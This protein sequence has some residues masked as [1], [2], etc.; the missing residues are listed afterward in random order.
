MSE[1]VG[2]LVDDVNSES[3]FPAIEI[4]DNELRSVKTRLSSE[5]RIPVHPELIRLGFIDYVRMLKAQSQKM[6]FPELI[7]LRPRTALATGFSKDWTPLLDE[8]LPDARKNDKTFHSFRKGGKTFRL[9]S[10]IEEETVAGNR[11]PETVL[12]TTFTVKAA[13]ELR[14]RISGRL[15]QKGFAAQAVRLLGAR[16][17]TVNSVCGGVVGEYSLALGLSPVA[18]VISDETQ[19]KIFRKAAD[20][21]IS[22][23]A[24]RIEEFARRLGQTEGQDPHDWRN[25][26]NAIVAAARGNDMTPEFFCDFARRSKQGF[27]KIVSHSRRAKRRTVLIRP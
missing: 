4:Q 21:A 24:E 10:M 15:L 20:A 14:E 1:I 11:K 3:E 19:V 26:V 23:H 7:I 25:D 8:A 17:G 2:L 13:E 12:A 9:T 22:R 6:L 18:E 16:I 27:A 5:R